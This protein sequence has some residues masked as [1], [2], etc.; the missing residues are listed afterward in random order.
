[1]TVYEEVIE[2]LNSDPEIGRLYGTL[3]AGDRSILAMLLDSE[4]AVGVTA[5]GSPNSQFWHCLTDIGWMAEMDDL[6]P[7]DALI[8]IHRY[9]I[10]DCGYRAIPV[11]LHKLPLPDY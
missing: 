3:S 4:D 6:L 7:G 11:L 2:E 8:Q 5:V 9:R 1:M 10:T